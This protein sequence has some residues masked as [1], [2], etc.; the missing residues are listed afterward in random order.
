MKSLFRTIRPQ[1]RT[2]YGDTYAQITVVAVD[3]DQDLDAGLRFLSELGGG[4]PGNA[5]D[6]IVLGGLWLN[7]QLVRF[8]WRENVTE[9]LT[10]QIV[11]VEPPVDASTYPVDFKLGVQADKVIAKKKGASEIKKWL[12]DGAP[13]ETS[14]AAA[15]PST[16]PR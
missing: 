7:E 13:L 3:M 16:G 8:I 10:P 5:F 14:T 2:K 15:Q 11:L 12:S 6:Q 4:S 1:L 9:A